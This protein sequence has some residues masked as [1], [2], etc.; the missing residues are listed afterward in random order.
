M[1]P[2]LTD[3]DGDFNAGRAAAAKVRQIFRELVGERAARVGSTA[4]NTP[5]AAALVAALASER[6]IPAPLAREISF[7][8]SDWSSDAAFIVALHLFPERFTAAEI[9]S[10]VENFLIHAPNHIAAAAVLFG[11][12]ID[13]IFEVGALAGSPPDEEEPEAT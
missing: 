8:L 13:D 10:A 6:D 3:A 5:G 7:H 2:D 12:P 4:V 1:T 11:Q 9:D